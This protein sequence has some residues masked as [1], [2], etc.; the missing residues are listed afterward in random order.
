MLPE[1]AGSRA[2]GFSE[3]D[4]EREELR[5]EVAALRQEAVRILRIVTSALEDGLQRR[6]AVAAEMRRAEAQLAALRDERA[7]AEDGLAHIRGELTLLEHELEAV[8]I[9]R[10]GTLM[11]TERVL[12]RALEERDTLVQEVAALRE[13]RADLATRAGAT[14]PGDALGEA[15]Y[16]LLE[17]EPEPGRISLKRYAAAALVALVVLALTILAAPV[18]SFSAW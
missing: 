9:Q 4:H 1:R 2:R 3:L 17:P 16:D 18:F 13:D 6:E 5:T 10:V 11:E 12:R 15:P 7:L 8:R 14:G